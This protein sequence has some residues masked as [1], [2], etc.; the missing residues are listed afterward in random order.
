[1]ARSIS[2]TL[3]KKEIMKKLIFKAIKDAL[4][5]KRKLRE[6]IDRLNSDKTH[7]NYQ[8]ENLTNCLEQRDQFLAELEEVL[9][10]SR[11]IR[12]EKRNYKDV[13]PRY[14][15]STS[16]QP[17]DFDFGKEETRYILTIEMMSPFSQKTKNFS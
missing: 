12:A 6:T 3:R 10:H 1:M 9:Y 7:L 14:I 8:V 5:P 17:L 4:V 13:Y 11:N 16:R 2:L 15:V